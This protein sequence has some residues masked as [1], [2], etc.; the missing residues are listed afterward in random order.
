MCAIAMISAPIANRSC[1]ALTIVLL[2]GLNTHAL[3]ARDCPLLVNGAPVPGVAGLLTDSGELLLPAPTMLHAL[4]VTVLPGEEGAPWSVRGCG[5]SVQVRPGSRQYLVGE[6]VRDARTATLL[7]DDGL[8]VPFEM[9]AETFGVEA[10]A[11]PEG[12]L[13]IWS[14]TTAGAQIMELR[15]GVHRDRLRLVIDLDRP[16]CFSA[17][18]VEPGRVVI[19][20][21]AAPDASGWARSVRLLQVEDPLITQIRQ[22]PTATGVVRISIGHT[23]PHPPEVFSLGEPPRIVVDL[24]R[25]EE[26][27]LPVPDVPEVPVAAGL[28]QVRNFSTPRG[29][30][31]VLVY[32]VDPRADAVEV[33]PAL[34]ADTIKH[35]VSVTR[36]CIN[37]GAYGG[38]NGGYFSYKGPPL[39]MLVIDREWIH[40]P[41]GGRTVL[42]ITGD[43][44]LLMDRLTFDGKVR[45]A[46]LGYLALSAINEGH[47]KPDTLVMYTR[48]WGWTVA[49]A[50]GRGRL[51]VDDTGRVIEK[52]T[53]GE[54]ITIPEGGFVLSGNGRMAKSLDKVEV[55]TVVTHELRT[56]PD[57]PD[58][59]HAI[60]GGPRLVK[61]GK[62]HIT[63]APEKFRADIYASVRPR[64]AVGITEDGR[65]L[66]VVVEGGVEGGAPGMSLSELATT[67]IKLGAWQAMNLDGGGSSTF[68][69]ER[70]LINLPSDGAARSVSNALLIFTRP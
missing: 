68:V 42:G 56:K 46:G 15:D 30:V 39:G 33:C 4:G 1:A 14:L 43:G 13:T 9:L 8:A 58:A 24:R 3:A 52:R 7:R 20:L 51:V 45:F 49:G 34:A 2:I 6:Q 25:A 21:P 59:V 55:G 28:V 53:N 70:R 26:D 48:R 69:A 37:S 36:M 63:A 12:D 11:V 50:T 41:Y 54:L 19:E 38:I 31:R 23:S 65:L 5:R 66:L 40:Q 60:G 61:N 17:L 44:H 64:S 47:S 32:D 27:Y 22:G 62:P 18:W 67:M 35:R 29:A 10:E 16:S 57:W